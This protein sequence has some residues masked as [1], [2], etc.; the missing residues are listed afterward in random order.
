MRP[1]TREKR[2]LLRL[3]RRW[4]PDVGR[5]RWRYVLPGPALALA[6]LDGFSMYLLR[7]YSGAPDLDPYNDVVPSY[8]PQGGYLRSLATLVGQ[9]PATGHGPEDYPPEGQH[10]ELLGPTGHGKTT[11][12]P[13]QLL[14]RI[15]FTQE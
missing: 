6:P 10:Q 7:Q 1:A 14:Q 5:K 13:F 11:M 15:V 9:T 12:D 4:G 2:A 8:W 3:V